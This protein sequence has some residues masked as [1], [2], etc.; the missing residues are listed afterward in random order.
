LYAIQLKW[1]L[2]HF[3]L[4]QNLLVLNYQQLHDNTPQV[5]EQILRFAGIPVVPNPNIHNDT[6]GSAGGSSFSK[7]RADERKHYRPLSNRTRTYLQQFYAP[8]NAD[9]EALLGPEW[10]VDKLGW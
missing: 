3:T 7:V 5:Y 9:L 1:W 8:Y 4:D 6:T 2:E 10:S